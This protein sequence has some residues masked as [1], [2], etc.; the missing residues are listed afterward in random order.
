MCPSTYYSYRQLN[1]QIVKTDSLDAYYV[2]GSELNH[3]KVHF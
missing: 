3:A 1:Y 2:T